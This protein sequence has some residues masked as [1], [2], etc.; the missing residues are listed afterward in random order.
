MRTGFTATVYLRREAPA[1]IGKAIWIR[2]QLEQGMQLRGQSVPIS[3]WCRRYAKS[4]AAA[5]GA[6]LSCANSRTVARPPLCSVLRYALLAQLVWIAAAL[7]NA[8]FP[9]LFDV[10]GSDRDGRSL[11]LCGKGG[12]EWQTVGL[13]GRLQ[14][15]QHAGSAQ[16]LVGPFENLAGTG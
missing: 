3:A 16:P 2:G 9:R 4:P 7:Q 5:P 11:G 6:E 14:G 1:E 10:K 13:R 15:I 12:V 8:S